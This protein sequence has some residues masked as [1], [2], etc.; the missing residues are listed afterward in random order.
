MA[1]PAADVTISSLFGLQGKTTIVTG[2]GAGIS[3]VIAHLFAKAGARVVV[4]DV[5]LAAAQAVADGINS[6][7]PGA[8]PAAV[9]VRVDIADEQSVIELFDRAAET[10]GGIDVVV[11]NSGIYEHTSFLETPVEKIRRVLEVNTIGTY[12]CMRQAIKRMQSAGKGGAIVNISSAASLSPVIFDNNDSGASK[13]G[14]NN[15]TQTAALEF[16][17]DQIRVNAVLPGG[18]ATE[19]ALSSV[20]HTPARG[21]MT[22]PD[23]FPLGRLA[24]PEDIAMAVLFLASPAASYIT[25]QLLAVDGGFQVS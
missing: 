21:P 2:A 5:N 8:D 16:A 1:N 9:A 14:V 25:G 22:Q 20:A 3:R 15:L 12:L 6:G 23:R 17:P 10:F 19:R 11:N 13:A 24:T 4:A 18:V 7:L